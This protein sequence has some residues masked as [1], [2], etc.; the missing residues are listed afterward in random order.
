MRGVVQLKEAVNYSED[1]INIDSVTLENFV[2]T[3]NLLQ[4]K[5]GLTTAVNLPPQEGRL[6]SFNSDN[7]LVANIRPYLKK[8]WFSNRNGG[9]SADVLVF[10]VKNEY[11][12]KFVYYSMYRD[13]FFNHMMRGAKGT[14]MPRGDKNQIMEFTLPNF[15]KSIQKK[16]SAVLSSLDAKIELN[17]RINV[18]L[19]AMAKTLYDYWFVQFDFP[20]S[21]EQAKAMGKPELTGKPYKS[22][23]GKMVYNETLKREIPERWEVRPLISFCVNIGDGIHGTPKYVE[24]SNYSFI[25]GNNLK[26]GFIQITKET[27][28]VSKDEYEKHY[29]EL[30]E[31]T[32]LLSINGTIGN[33]AVY[34][35]EKVMLGKSAAY[36]NCKDNYR[37]YCYQYLKMKNIQQVLWSIATGSTIKNLSLDSLK[38]LLLPMPD[39]KTSELFYN[40]L[41]PI[42]TKRQSIFQQNQQLAQLRDWLLPM[43]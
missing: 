17:N 36:I 7:I 26:N 19:E 9:C 25:N 20:I 28:K 24:A 13:D 16:I 39:S 18:E 43:L 2:T 14:K 32:I 37:P 5:L 21:K 12:P 8:I 40:L 23:G 4:N 34:S 15:K 33:L 41:K 42:D 27:K 29:I 38:M 1:R 10:T 30:N 35:G 6:P 22:S 31:E 3:D 11:D